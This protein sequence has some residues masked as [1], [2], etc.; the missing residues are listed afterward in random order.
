MEGA[1]F[2]CERLVRI[3]AETVKA[4]AK[5]ANQATKARKPGTLKVIRVSG[6]TTNK[7]LPARPSVRRTVRAGQADC[8]NLAAAQAETESTPAKTEGGREGRA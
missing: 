3:T 1:S 2:F 7:R 4:V 6:E 5:A 8:P